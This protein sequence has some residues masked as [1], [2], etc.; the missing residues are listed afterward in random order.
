MA[1]VERMLS[2]VLLIS[3]VAMI[4]GCRIEIA[5]P[6]GGKVVGDS[7][8]YE[9]FAGTVCSIDV[10]DFSFDE[11]FSAVATGSDYQFSHWRKRPGGLCGGQAEP[12]TID[13][14]RAADHPNLTDILYSDRSFYLEPVFARPATRHK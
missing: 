4:G 10:D 7:G 11:T 6:E 14:S 13:A 12:C 2:R 3:A 8:S 5:V 9:C 1:G